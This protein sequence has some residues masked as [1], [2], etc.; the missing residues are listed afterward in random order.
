MRFMTTIKNHLMMILLLIA[1][2]VFNSCSREYSSKNKDDY[3]TFLGE[4][5]N[6]ETHMPTLDEIGEY[7][8][9]VITRK[10]PND[11]FF[12]TTDSIA[13][14]VSYDKEM[15]QNELAKIAAKYHFINSET[16]AFSDY[17]A[18]VG[19]YCFKVDANSLNPMVKYPSKEEIYE[20]SC[21][22]FIGVNTKEN[23]IAYLY[24]WDVEIHHIDDLDGFVCE[25]FVLE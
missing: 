1:V 7:E 9:L 8:S 10:T 15:F 5:Y 16:D 19:D 13:L 25:N 18:T 14:I 17:E 6:A 24:Y 22:L 21:S 4:V 3:A 2:L 23:K 20:P 12:S 11:V